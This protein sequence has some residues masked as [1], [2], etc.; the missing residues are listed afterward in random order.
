MR[1]SVLSL[2]ERSRYCQSQRICCHRHP[3]RLGCEC[4]PGA[5]HFRPASLVRQRPRT[6]G[7]GRVSLDLRDNL[8]VCG[9]PGYAW[10]CWPHGRSSTHHS[11][12]LKLGPVPKVAWPS[13]YAY[14]V[15]FRCQSS[16]GTQSAPTPV[17]DSPSSQTDWCSSCSGL[18]I[19]LQL[20]GAA[21]ELSLCSGRR[22]ANLAK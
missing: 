17:I 3:R 21:V 20:C 9:K 4:E 19:A 8:L 1:N 14:R 12:Q 16:K 7:S 5:W 2:G 22:I 18:T 13:G 6:I 10:S 15:G 11:R